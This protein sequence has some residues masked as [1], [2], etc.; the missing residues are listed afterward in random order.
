M[1]RCRVYRTF[2][3][4]IGFILAWA[5]TGCISACVS[6]LRV[7]RN[8]NVSS[9]SLTVTCNAEPSSFALLIGDGAPFSAGS[10]ILSVPSSFSAIRDPVTDPV[11]RDPSR[12]RIMVTKLFLFRLQIGKIQQHHVRALLCSFE[13]N[14]MAVWGDVEIANV[15][16]RT[17]IGQLPLS[18]VLQ[19]KQPKILMLDLP[20]E[21]HECASTI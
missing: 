17:K 11:N 19:V 16:V 6:S 4:G 3:A 14:F 20:A 10:A 7:T 13:D 1:G 15:E 9:P 21:Q 5:P 2:S 12:A 18:A 8:S